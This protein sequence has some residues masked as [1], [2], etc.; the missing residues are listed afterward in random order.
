MAKTG[1]YAAAYARSIED[2]TSFWGD[3]AEAIDWDTPPVTVLDA[4]DAPYFRWFSGGRLNTCWHH[5][6]LS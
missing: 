4:S 2:P 5:A 6:T 1:P 3:A